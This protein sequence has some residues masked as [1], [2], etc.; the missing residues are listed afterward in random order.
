MRLYCEREWAPLSGRAEASA[1]APS[2]EKHFI[3][4]VTDA[5]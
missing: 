2:V 4:K 1:I 3:E 5:E